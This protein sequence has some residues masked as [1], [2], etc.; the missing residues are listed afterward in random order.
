MT[1][2]VGLLIVITRKSEGKISTLL[3][4]Y[5][6]FEVA[7]SVGDSFAWFIYSP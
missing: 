4:F 2:L 6:T 7:E 1:G 5:P 3:F